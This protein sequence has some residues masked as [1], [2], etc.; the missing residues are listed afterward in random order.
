M[1]RIEVSTELLAGAMNKL[2]FGDRSES[3]DRAASMARYVIRSLVNRYEYEHGGGVQN[4]GISRAAT[5]PIG[6]H[7]SGP[8]LEE[9]VKRIA[10]QGSGFAPGPADPF[11]DSVTAAGLSGREL[12]IVAAQFLAAVDRKLLPDEL[13]K[14]IATSAQFLLRVGLER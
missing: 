9:F 1:S 2:T 13:E 7:P 14:S 6:P 4:G 11:W 3:D 12:L 5:T 8:H 10:G